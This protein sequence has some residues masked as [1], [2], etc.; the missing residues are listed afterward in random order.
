MPTAVITLSSE[1]TR[2][3]SMICVITPETETLAGARSGCG[4][5]LA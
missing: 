4:P 1:N 5:A 3:M 2:S